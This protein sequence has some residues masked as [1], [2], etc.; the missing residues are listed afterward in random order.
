MKVLLTM[1]G[2]LCGL[3]LSAQSYIKP[4]NLPVTDNRTTNIIFPSLIN[5][6]DRG[7]ERIVVQK[8]T[9][10]VLRVKADSVFADTTTLTVITADGKLYSFLV[11]YIQ[12]PPF[13]NL[14]LAMAEI[15]SVDTALL[16]LSQKAL[17]L[18]NNLH[19]IGYSAGMVKLSLLG[20]YTTGSIIVCKIRVENASA[21]QFDGSR[22]RVYI[23]GA[24]SSKRRSLQES[25]VEPLFIYP[26][27]FSVKVKQ[28]LLM[29]LLLPKA[30]LAE[31][32][33]LRIDLLEKDGE[34]QLSL[35]ITNK[36]VL[37]AKLIL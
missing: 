20:M 21:Y 37:K 3:L 15:I 4:H 33:A 6:V 24:R 28:S 13:L 9:G 1:I 19:G 12:S 22:L 17:A 18:K 5:T 2:S 16:G 32:Q 30:A 34:R 27:A 7:S 10:N 26:K 11:S 35:N 25:I 14:D 29:A 31:S 8:S 23:T 36:R